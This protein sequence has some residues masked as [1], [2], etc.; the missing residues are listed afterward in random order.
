MISLPPAQ[1]G[2]H[3]FFA[4]IH[5]HFQTLLTQFIGW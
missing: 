5:N 3:G 1:A 4:S 2:G